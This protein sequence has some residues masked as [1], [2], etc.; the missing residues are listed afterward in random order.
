MIEV[1]IVQS[2]VDI[3][4][5]ENDDVRK[6]AVHLLGRMEEHGVISYSCIISW[7]DW[8]LTENFVAVMIA[9]GAVKSIVN[10]LQS[11]N[12]YVK[13]TAVFVLS[14]L[15]EHCTINYPHWFPN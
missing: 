8:C 10:I 14:R 2:I 1:G 12:D 15:E 6:V 3:L 5:S 11:E 9:A 4:H 7:A 13:N